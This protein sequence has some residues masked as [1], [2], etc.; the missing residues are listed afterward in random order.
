MTTVRVRFQ[1]GLRPK[2]EKHAMH[3][4]QTHGSWA[5]EKTGAGNNLNLSEVMNLISGYDSLKNNVYS[6]EDTVNNRKNNTNKTPPPLAPNHPLDEGQDYDTA[7]REYNKK[8]LEWAI[9]TQALVLSEK[10]K[11]YLDGSPAG[12]KKY[13]DDVIKQDWFIERFGNG[14][15]LPKLQVKTANTNAAGR[16]ILRMTKNQSNGG[17]VKQENIISID[18]QATKDESTILHEISHYATVISQTS[19]YSAHGFEFARNHV[20]VVGK[21]V[22]PERAARLKKAYIAKGIPIND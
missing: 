2:I 10:G 13:V 21:A 1:P 3:D 20:Y 11:T 17:I 8:W 12:V 15:S 9:E 7:Y 4:Q 19:R 5:G 6:A 22:S 18:R 16:H 14:S